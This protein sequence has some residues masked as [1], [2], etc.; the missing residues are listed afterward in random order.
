MIDYYLS[1]GRYEQFL[2]LVAVVS[3]IVFAITLCVEK[4]EQYELGISAK[5]GKSFS[6]L[7]A[8]SALFVFCVLTLAFISKG[9]R[10]YIAYPISIIITIV[11]VFLVL[12]I[13]GGTKKIK[14]PKTNYRI[15]I[16]RTGVVYKPIEADSSKGCV[17][18]DAFGDTIEAYAISADSEP[19]ASGTLIKVIDIDGDVLV[20]VPLD[21]E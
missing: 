13:F 20:C 10:W 6:V 11:Y 19:I 12:L 4:C 15:A 5:R 2:L 7:T 9:I 17:S 18:V 8:M 14:R 3:G 21:K 16:G 1:L